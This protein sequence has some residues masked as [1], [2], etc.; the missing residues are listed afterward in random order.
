MLEVKNFLIFP[1]REFL[2]YRG[3]NQ[4]SLIIVGEG[5][6]EPSTAPC[7]A[8]TLISPREGQRGPTLTSRSSSL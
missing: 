6:V 2:I 5:E 3:V 8:G 1:T 4:S 7:L